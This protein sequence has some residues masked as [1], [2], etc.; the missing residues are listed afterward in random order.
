TVPGAE[1]AAP[2]PG[3]A[4]AVLASGSVQFDGNGQ[5]TA[6]T[7]TAPSTGSGTAP[8]IADVQFN[9]VAWANGAAA[10]A[11]TWDLVDAN[12]VISLT[13]YQSPSATSSKTQNGKPA[14]LIDGII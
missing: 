9:T 10:S 6:V 13:G 5:I 11:M 4:P 8:N 1:V 3:G 12:N 2:P 7:P 14:G